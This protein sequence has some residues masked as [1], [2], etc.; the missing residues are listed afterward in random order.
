MFINLCASQE[1]KEER[2]NAEHHADHSRQ[3]EAR[4]QV[5]TSN[6]NQTDITLLTP[7]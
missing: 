3:L 5:R 6:R 2:A 1:L 7:S 4:F